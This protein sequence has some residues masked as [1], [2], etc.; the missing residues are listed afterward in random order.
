MAPL[1]SLPNEHA[2]TRRRRFFVVLSTYVNVPSATHARSAFTIVELLVVIALIGILVAL[3]IPAV[4]KV[5]ETANRATCGNNLKQ[6][7]LATQ[8]YEAS[9]NMLPSNSQGYEAFFAKTWRSWPSQSK[10]RS[11]SWL[12]RLL[13]YI[14]QQDLYRQANIP[15][16]TL[17]ESQSS[18]AQTVATFFCPSDR[19]LTQGTSLVC[20]NLEGVS[21]ALTNYKGVSG[22]NWCWGLYYNDGPTG[23]CN[24]LNA[25]DGVFFR[26][27]WK[28]RLRFAQITDGMSNTL[29]IGEGIPDLDTHCC[30]PY[31]NTSV[32]TCAIPP[33]LGLTG[34]LFNPKNWENVYSFRSRHSGGLQF[35]LA[36]GS[37]RFIR[38]VIAPP[39]YRA[40]ATRNGGEAV[41]GDGLD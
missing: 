38:E 33:N 19:A 8:N 18:I 7:A 14:E 28:I 1:I 30:W 40:M 6:L 37:V 2:R 41:S 22:S 3:L 20:Q 34:K 4:Q 13:P 11:W 12:A 26:D 31:A 17:G 32:A 10:Q 25:G 5:R 24:G 29:L 23:N 9:F 21:I 39:T 27:D 16:N 35:A 15:S 36:D